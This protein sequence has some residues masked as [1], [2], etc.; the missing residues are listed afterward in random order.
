MS[1]MFVPWRVVWAG[2]FK[3]P[4]PSRGRQMPLGMVPGEGQWDFQQDLA[5]RVGASSVGT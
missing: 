1:S 3:S 5:V 2:G 4:S